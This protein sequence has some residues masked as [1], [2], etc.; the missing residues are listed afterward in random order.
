MRASSLFGVLLGAIAF[1]VAAPAHAKHGPRAAL[2]VETKTTAGADDE[3]LHKVKSSA[4]FEV[5]AHDLRLSDARAARLEHIAARYFEATHR[6]ITITGGTRSAST[7]AKLMIEKLEHGDDL[8]ALYPDHAALG[9]IVAAYKEKKTHKASKT[10]IERAVREAIEAQMKKGVMISRHLKSGA[11]DVRSF[12]MSPTQ[13]AAFK[14]AVAKEPGVILLD[15]RTQ[16][17]PHFHLS[18]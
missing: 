10:A 3:A 16:A 5:V 17:E 4:H 12:G 18:L 14:A 1:A 11:A 13:V 2:K 15:E 6:K 9:E 8:R 7:Q